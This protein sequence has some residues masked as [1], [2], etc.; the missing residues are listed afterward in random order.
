MTTN[1]ILG[2]MPT[3]VSMTEIDEKPLTESEIRR[4]L[5]GKMTREKI[6][7]Y[8]EMHQEKTKRNVIINPLAKE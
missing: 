2:T 4:T 6:D 5:A 7:R 1:K 3:S 8:I